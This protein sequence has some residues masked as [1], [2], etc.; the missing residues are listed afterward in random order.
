MALSL[1]FALWLVAAAEPQ[2]YTIR[3]E[4]LDNFGDAGVTQYEGHATLAGAGLWV[5]ADRLVHDANQDVITA[6]GQVVVR[7]DQG[8]KLVVVGEV[9]SLRLEDDEVRDIYALDGHA[10][11]RKDVSAAAL[12]AVHTPEDADR[13]GHIQ[14]V[15]EGNHFIHH[16]TRWGAERVSLTPC[17]CDLSKPSWHI[18]AP[19]ATVDSVGERV[20]VVAPLIK[21]K[22]V[23]VL[24][25]PWLSLPLNDRQ[26]GLLFPRPG[27]GPLIG[28]SY[29]QPA[30][31]TLGRSADLTLTPGYFTGAD[32][33]AM[34]GFGVKGPR[35]GAELRYTPSR[36]TTGRLLLGVLYDLN[37]QRDP[38]NASLSPE[39]KA[40]R[41]LRGELA[42]QHLQ[43]LDG[44]FGLRADLNLHSDGY[45]IRDVTPDVIAAT[46]G[47]L[48]SPL[49][50]F[51]RAADS[52]VSLEVVLRQDLGTGYNLL[53]RA[54][55][56]DPASGAPKFGPGTLQR[57]PSL[58]ATLP[59]HPLL[60]PL[61]GGVTAEYTRLSPI[62]S[63][64]GDEGVNA[65][66]GSTLDAS[67]HELSW[68][69]Q[70]NRLYGSGN[71]GCVDA[72]G[73][74]VPVDRTSMGDRRWQPGEREARDRWMAV[75]RL[76]V[77]GAAFGLLSLSAAAWWRQLAWAGEE[78]GRTWERG[79]LV[80]DAR[81]E[82]EASRA[83]GAW[84]HTV[85][86]L[87]EVRS[88]PVVLSGGSDPAS[89][90]PVPYDEVDAAI[91]PGASAG[92]T[93]G[94]AEL[95]QRL[96]RAGS[97][98][99]LR[100]DLGQGVWLRAPGGG[101]ALSAGES[102]GRLAVTVWWVKASA[103]VRVDPVLKRLTRVQATAGLDDAHGHGVAASYENLL[104]D[105]TDRTR[106][107]LDL[108]FGLP[109]PVTSPTDRG[110]LLSVG[111]YWNF[112]P[113]AVR[114]DL[115]M[116][117]QG[118]APPQ[119]AQPERVF[120]LAQHGLTV[121]FTPAC[122]CWRLDL[123]AVQRTS[124][125]TLLVPNFGATLTVAHFGSIGSG[126]AR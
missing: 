69:C 47:Y 100:L 122:D 52:L 95:R 70:A 64:T 65:G 97:S 25:L 94:V 3:A 60:G 119:A 85:T 20:A 1:S 12:A 14:A 124:G 16:G 41:G 103:T 61:S 5:D 18:E 50:A 113:V 72:G 123:T 81:A 11:M 77:S 27:Y 54:Q 21:V 48:R 35:L 46:Q 58:S 9:V 8:S 13:L 59:L 36:Q 120:G 110:Q 10:T 125:S 38:F 55:Y 29:E 51:H 74:V 6:V 76:Q 105:G 22:Q 49:L 68:A 23:P 114:Y 96:T 92:L 108:L 31:F 34:G 42:W 104:D 57:L 30:Y 78:S 44:G 71:G 83:F 121:G 118:W 99:S 112:G 126:S 26:T 53:G 56:L 39:S 80:L 33:A 87:V 15:L 117:E 116:T 106:T 89:R 90:T 111:A 82:T 45:Y 66:E 40:P 43:D 24:W 62:F 73:V 2:A 84:R 19:G 32:T 79:T 93:Q 75:P 37:A 63:L 86:P 17:D 98:D 107:P 88:V 4:N 67:G 28:F 109:V 115:L 101:Q 7:L 91:P 102:Y